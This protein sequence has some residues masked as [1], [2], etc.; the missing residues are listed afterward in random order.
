MSVVGS[1]SSHVKMAVIGVGAL[2]RHHARILAG[3]P[4]VELVAVVDP[5]ETQG[6]AV[7]E[8]HSTRWV[9]N[10]QEI[11]VSCDA[12]SVVA[13]TFLH[14]KIAVECLSQGKD[15]LVEKPLTASVEQ[16]LELNHLARKHHRRPAGRFTDPP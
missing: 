11:L 4:G 13:P 8:Q 10:Y 6:R 14:H 12:F 1:Q 16:A 15:L 9:A 3:M 2:G 7:A 5:N